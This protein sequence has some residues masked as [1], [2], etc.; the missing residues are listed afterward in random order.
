MAAC[1]DLAGSDGLTITHCAAVRDATRATQMHLEPRKW[2]PRRAPVC[3]PGR[4]PLDVFADDLEDP[5]RRLGSQ[6][7]VGTRKGWYYPQNPNDDRAWDGT[8]AS[9]G[10]TNLYA[11]DYGSRSDTVIQTR[12]PVQLP[13]GAFLRFEHGYSFDASGSRRYDGGIVEVKIGGGPWQGLNALFT[14]GGYNGQIAQGTGS[15]L[16]GRRAYTGDSHGWSSARAD[17]SSLRRSAAEAPLPHGLG[18]RR[19]RPGLVRR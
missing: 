3:A 8:W 14:H 1:T 17:L 4:R 13:A 19:E 11:P 10:A 5:R 6:R 7:L 12:D 2:A 15:T 16:A 18:P 9:S